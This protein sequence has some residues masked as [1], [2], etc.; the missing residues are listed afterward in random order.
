M[1]V[2]RKDIKDLLIHHV[3]LRAPPLWREM[4]LELQVLGVQLLV[5]APV[6]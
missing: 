3:V 6:R 1:D 2:F 5:S 4:V